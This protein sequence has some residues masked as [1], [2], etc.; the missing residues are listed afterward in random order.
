MTDQTGTMQSERMIRV[1]EKLVALAERSEQ[2]FEHLEKALDEIR[3]DVR[4]MKDVLVG[5]ASGGGAMQ[6]LGSLESSTE[7][8]AHRADIV[9]TAS[10]DHGDRLTRLEQRMGLVLWVL[11]A[12]GTAT[13][14]LIVASLWKLT[15][16]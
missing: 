16:L 7:A 5:D 15:H 6:R 3:G 13:V 11:A 9:E 12:V 1:E 2:R 14:G 8:L 4:Q 10:R